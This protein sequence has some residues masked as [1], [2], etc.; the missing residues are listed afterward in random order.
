MHPIQETYEQDRQAAEERALRILPKLSS[1]VP[2]EIKLKSSLIQWVFDKQSQG[3]ALS[4][5]YLAP[6]LQKC[7]IVNTV[8]IH[9][10]LAN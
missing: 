6:L 9:S 1:L 8:I 5:V 3:T 7:L 10:L 4:A 2:D